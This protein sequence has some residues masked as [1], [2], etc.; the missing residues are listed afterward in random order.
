MAQRTN[1]SRRKFLE[2]AAIAAGAVALGGPGAMAGRDK[3]A[4][5]PDPE[6]SGIDHVVVMMMENRSFDHMLGW[7]PGADGAQAGLTYFDAAGQPHPTHALA[8]DPGCG[9]PDPITR[10]RAPASS[11]TAGRATDG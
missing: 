11:T 4:G 8:P 3:G 2:S 10:T 6:H 7:L 1:V 9:H 5:L